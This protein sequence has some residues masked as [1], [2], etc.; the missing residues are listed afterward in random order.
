MRTSG[1]RTIFSTGFL[2]TALAL[3]PFA[4]P[5]MSA[6]KP[7]APAKAPAAKPS[8]PAKSGAGASRGPSTASHG[9]TTASHGPTTSSHGP[10]TS[11][12]HTTT[13]HTT[14]TRTTTTH[15]TA[16][17]AGHTAAGG[18]GHS[19]STGGKSFG[20][21]GGHTATA[22]HTQTVGS[23]PVARNATVHQTRNGSTVVKRSD[24][25]VATVHD[26]RRGVD[27]HRGLNGNRM[28]MHERADHSRV[29]AER[30][31]RGYVQR[32]YRFH[33]HE[34]ARRSYYYHGHYYHAYYGRYY[35]HGMY[36]NPYYPA[37]YYPPAYYGWVYNP[38]VSPIR[39]SWGWAGNP[40]YGY[41]GAYFTPYPVYAS[42]SLWLTDYIIANSLAAA[43][44]AQVDAQVQAA[45]L[46]GVTPLSP[47]TKQLIADEVKNQIAIENAEAAKGSSAD[48]QPND[49]SS[50]IQR[51][52][53]DGHSHVFV[54]GSDVDVVD[55][56][57][58]E[59]ALSLGDAVQLSPGPN[60]PD[61]TAVNLAVLASKGGKECPIGDTV[62]VQLADLQEM[63]N[64]MRQTIDQGM[65][66][67]QAKQG[68]DGIP[69]P[70]A[71][72][73]GKPVESAMAAAAPPPPPEDEVKG[74]INQES[75]EADAVEKD[76][77]TD[78]A[79]SSGPNDTAA[80][81]A[82]APEVKIGQSIDQVVAAFGQPTKTVNLGAKKIYVYK[83]L[84]VT[85]IDGKVSDVQ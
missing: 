10:T 67:L 59:C 13:T 11:T 39:F 51:M 1:I 73:Q 5:G 16:G 82:E 83:D 34:Y 79:A 21:G 80:A 3:L 58:N 78:T 53:D 14:T 6:S 26:A 24:G 4:T 50:S 81:P 57:G 65:Q 56:G 2:A 60:A 71:S 28:A 55:A 22:G 33:G 20:S 18:A 68:K 31:G 52:L 29:F 38:W 76:A 37:Y 70:P 9:P 25:R 63:Q 43:Y 32:P 72:A 61:A 64:H 41:Y 74:E 19:A 36:L 40:W 12:T 15:T 7:S 27:V 8:A 45:A 30:G 77:A 54:A 42:A 46:N 44:Q 35:Y 85:F 47:E 75:K 48:A 66:E 84:K 17:G 49:A 23:H 69:A 62:S